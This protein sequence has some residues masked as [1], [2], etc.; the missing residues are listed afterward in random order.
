MGLAW[1]CGMGLAWGCHGGR[2]PTGNGGCG[3]AKP[4]HEKWRGRTKNDEKIKVSRMEFSIV[5]K[6]SGLQESILAYL[7]GPNS[8]LI[9]NSK[10]GRII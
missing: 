6:L 9:K 2:R 10:N 7:E 4:P 3:G 8:I 5:E 1:G